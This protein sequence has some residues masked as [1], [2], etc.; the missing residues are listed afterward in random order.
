MA[1]DRVPAGLWLREARPADADE[2]AHAACADTDE[3]TFMVSR[4]GDGP[5]PIEAVGGVFAGLPWE[6][7]ERTVVSFFG[8]FAEAAASLAPDPGGE[9]SAP[10]RALALRVGEPVRCYTGVPLRGRDGTRQVCAVTAAGRATW[11]PF[12][13]QMRYHPVAEMPPDVVRLRQPEPGFAPG[14]GGLIRLNRRWVAEVVEAGLWVRPADSP[15]GA[16]VVRG[17]GIDPRSCVVVFGDMRVGAAGL[18]WRA[19]A[20]M[21][22]GLP[23]DARDRIR[24][25]LPPNAT[26]SD[27]SRAER[28]CGA[29]L[30]G[31]PIRRLEPATVGDRRDDE[32][33]QFDGKHAMNQPTVDEPTMDQPTVDRATVDQPTVDQSAARRPIAGR[34][35]VDLPILDLPIP[36][37][38]VV[39][40]PAPSSDGPGEVTGT[41]RQSPQ[42]K[43]PAV[44]PSTRPDPV[45]RAHQSPARDPATP[46]PKAAPPP[47]PAEPA[48]APRRT[49]P[50]PPTFAAADLGRLSE[51]TERAA[52]RAALG[53][54]FDA[55]AGL[56]NRLLAEWPGLRHAY[57]DDSPDALL[58]ELIAVR[59]YL[60]GQARALAATMRT[61]Q[62][63]VDHAA[64]V[65]VASGLRRLAVHSGPVFGAVADGP[66]LR[67]GYR[68]GVVLFDRGFAVATPDPRVAVAGAAELPGVRLASFAE[69]LLWSVTGRRLAGLQPNSRYER[70]AFAAGTRIRV[71]AVDGGGGDRPARVFARE[72]PAGPERPEPARDDERLLARLVLAAVARDAVPPGLRIPAEPADQLTW[73]AEPVDARPAGASARRST[74]RA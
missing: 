71:L 51:P 42:P 25:I 53:W 48:P 46:L 60:D 70:V 4:P 64:V 1:L 59:A 37:L 21:L 32:W 74:E 5:V 66:V 31:E 30:R 43:A 10:G 69:L 2:I 73:V 63:L 61:G 50:V 68:A 36:D 47:M 20:R 17:L 19:T 11:R 3:L 29:L 12:A 35:I 13:Q 15:A 16:V 57:A 7:R 58:T 39:D 24:A 56:V 33:Q 27:T 38:P 45:E 44:P 18:P 9:G 41:L 72:L 26:R 52:V 34:P 67:G 54:Q 6:L 14:P 22:S 8:P 65:C 55:H 49:S 40:R 28:A 23:R 62:P